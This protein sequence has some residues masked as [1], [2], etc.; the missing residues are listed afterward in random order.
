MVSCNRR[1]NSPATSD[2]TVLSTELCE[3]GNPRDFIAY[4]PNGEVLAVCAEAADRELSFHE[5]FGQKSSWRFVPK[6]EQSS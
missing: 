1:E 3:H 2:T 6:E 5:R 4:G